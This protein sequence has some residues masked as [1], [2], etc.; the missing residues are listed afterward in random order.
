MLTVKNAEKIM[1]ISERK[2]EMLSPIG[3]I[4]ER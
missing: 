4:Y 2:P 1:C 3:K